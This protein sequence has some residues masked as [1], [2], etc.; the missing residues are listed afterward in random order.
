MSLVLH[1]VR[2]VRNTMELFCNLEILPQECV[3]IMGPKGCG[4]TSL[5]HLIAG[6]E[7]PVSGSIVFNRQPL[8]C[9]VPA[10]RPLTI[11]LHDNNL[12]N[13]LSIGDNVVLGL[14]GTLSPSKHDQE[15]VRWM[16]WWLGLEG[17]E[18]RK[19]LDVSRSHQQ[20]AALARCI[21]QN[22]PLLLLDDLFSVFEEEDKHD[23]LCLIKVLQK[24]FG[25][26]T[27]FATHDRDD[28]LFLASK[29]LLMDCGQVVAYEPT[30]Q[31]SF[32]CA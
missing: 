2:L 11:L 17:L 24:E 27:L 14:R 8:D 9:L 16:M 13:H 26:T 19:P 32:A 1:N 31:Q 18:K 4:K 15:L 6:L 22:K 28:A 10:S 12:F 29:T 5:L 7:R 20:R 25:L 21:L 30:H 23:I 3:A